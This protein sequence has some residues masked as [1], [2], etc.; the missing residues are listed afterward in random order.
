MKR[1][2]INE[3]S[4]PTSPTSIVFNPQVRRKDSSKVPVYDCRELVDGA[5]GRGK[6]KKHEALRA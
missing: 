6:N 4:I 5:L 2:R 1:S 3:I